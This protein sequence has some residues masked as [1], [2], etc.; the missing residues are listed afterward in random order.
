MPAPYIQDFGDEDHQEGETGL[1]VL[2]FDLGP[3]IP[4]PGELWMHQNADPLSPGLADQLTVGTWTDT[5]LTGVEIPAAP[6]NSP[7][8]VY[9]AIK[10][11]GDN[12]W[13]V[14]DF[15]FT[16]TSAAGTSVALTG[17]ILTAREPDI[18]TGGRTIILTLTND[19]WQ[20]LVL[21]AQRQAIINGCTSAQSELTGWN[22]EVRD[23]EPDTSVVR[24]SDTVVTITWSAAAAYDITAPETIT[25][26]VPASV[27]VTSGSPVVA[28]PS[29]MINLPL[30]SNYVARSMVSMRAMMAS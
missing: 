5:S 30:V 14:V 2:G 29:F 21:A 28:S 13:N 26:T 12:A 17:T 9:L 11:Y 25:V 27:L 10:R 23:N 7:G 20:P 22:N 1:T 4:A 3:G 15:P 18:V 8:T 19:T 24:T 16:L 6:N